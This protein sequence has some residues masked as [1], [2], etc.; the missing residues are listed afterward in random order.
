MT[1][2]RKFLRFLTFF[3][4]AIAKLI[5]ILYID[6]F[7]SNTNSIQ[8]MCNLKNISISIDVE[9][10]LYYQVEKYKM[11]KKWLKYHEICR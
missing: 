3:I 6:F 4:S 9:I 2:L 1:S 10:F 5:Y 8:S 11:K 7:P